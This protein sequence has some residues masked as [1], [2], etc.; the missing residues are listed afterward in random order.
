MSGGKRREIARKGCRRNA[1]TFS[2][3]IGINGVIMGLFEIGSNA[4]K[5]LKI[6]KNNQ[7]ASIQSDL[8][9]NSNYVDRAL[10]GK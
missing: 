1:C 6:D 4:I 8:I 7:S 3:M 9:I 2:F 5:N 10:Q